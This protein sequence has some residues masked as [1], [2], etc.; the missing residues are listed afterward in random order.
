MLDLAT[1]AFNRPHW[2]GEQIRLFAKFVTD[3]HRLLVI[4]NSD[5]ESAAADIARV[6]QT[7]GTEYVR[8]R[9]PQ[10]LHHYAL[11]LAAKMLDERGAEA[12]GFLDHDIFPSCPVSLMAL[13]E[14]AGFFAIQQRHH[15][16]QVVYP[17]PCF[18]LL[19]R[20]WLAGRALN[21]DGIRAADKKDD[22]D[23]GSGLWPLFTEDDWNRVPAVASGYQTVRPPDGYGTQ[24]S[25]IERVS[26][27][28]HLTN[29]SGWLA[30]PDAAAREKI[31]RE[32]IAAL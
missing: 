12:Y 4:D 27:M 28:L 6:C 21:F 29:A 19:S 7:T 23:T 11:N 3:D 32:M 26:D 10:H 31:L 9:P 8:V 2:I 5:E 18:F 13:I 20:E 24:S 16:T 14:S 22:G 30:V 17:H 25:S 1:I 15:A